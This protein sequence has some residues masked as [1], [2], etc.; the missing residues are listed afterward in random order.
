MEAVQ[1]RS[2]LAAHVDISEHLEGGGPI[3]LQWLVSFGDD[4]PRVAAYVAGPT[5]VVR[6][7]VWKDV[8]PGL[9]VSGVHLYPK[10]APLVPEGTPQLAAAS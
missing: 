2:D 9:K 4:Q 5:G 7:P 1:P 6:Y 8:V 3:R 10:P